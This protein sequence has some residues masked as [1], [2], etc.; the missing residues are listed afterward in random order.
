MHLAL[1]TRHVT[2]TSLCLYLR[3]VEGN[4]RDVRCHLNCSHLWPDVCHLFLHL[5]S[6]ASLINLNYLNLKLPN[7]Y[8]LFFV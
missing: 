5:V 4:S 8:C 7:F 2:C 1:N 6:E 3:C